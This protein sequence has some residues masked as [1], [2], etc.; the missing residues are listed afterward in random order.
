MNTNI[1]ITIAI[2]AVGIVFGFLM[3]GAVTKSFFAGLVLAKFFAIAPIITVPEINPALAYAACGLGIFAMLFLIVPIGK[4]RMTS[5]PNESED[6]AINPNPVHHDGCQPVTL[7]ADAPCIISSIAEN[8]HLEIVL[9]F[10]APKRYA[11][12]SERKIAFTKG[13]FS[14]H[15]FTF[16][17][18]CRILIEQ[19]KQY[20]FAAHATG[21]I[22]F[23]AAAL[24]RKLTELLQE[25]PLL[26]IF[27]GH[28]NEISFTMH[29]G[30][31]KLRKTTWY[32]PPLSLAA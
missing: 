1:T 20:F 21:A 17:E 4:A 13:Q 12:G 22:E 10:I 25:T 3:H 18:V 28:E 5:S 19:D 26:P 16:S 31:R 6:T 11:I 15:A 8:T 32:S 27:A 23:L 30:L 14:G 2:A 7:F 24:R 29:L 9:E